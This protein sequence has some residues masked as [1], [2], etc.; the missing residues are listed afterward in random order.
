MMIRVKA[1]LYN[2]I[3]KLAKKDNRSITNMTNVLIKKQ[4][5]K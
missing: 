5:K 3:V 1:E 2:E 4:L